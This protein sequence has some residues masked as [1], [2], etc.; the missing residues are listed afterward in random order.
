VNIRQPALPF[1]VFTDAKGDTRCINALHVQTFIP[2]PFGDRGDR[3]TLI[4]F[5]NGDTVTVTDDFD[6]IADQFMS[7]RAD[8]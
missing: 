4:T 3:G 1:H 7:D 5:A 2:N 8:G 6:S